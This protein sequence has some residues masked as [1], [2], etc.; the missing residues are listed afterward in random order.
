MTRLGNV[1]FLGYK[2][3]SVIFPIFGRKILKISSIVLISTIIIFS[4]IIISIAAYIE[5]SHSNFYYIE[6][7]IKNK[8]I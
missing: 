2:G 4:S 5:K 6:D 1:F 3:I 7:Y 8:H